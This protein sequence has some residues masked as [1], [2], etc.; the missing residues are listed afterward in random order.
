M[1]TKFC[2]SWKSSIQPRKQR[3]YIYNCPLHI[4]RKFLKCN[5][6]KFLRKDIKKR[7]IVVIKGDKIRVMRGNFKDKE[8]IVKN[9][10]IKKTKIY[11][12]EIKKKEKKG[13]EIFVPL[14][15]SNVQ[16]IELNLKDTKR[17]NK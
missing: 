1:K 9:T 2:A 8:G 16:I 12:E 3:K 13:K 4:K 15:P 6:S 5:L 11:V 10:D 17:I 7:N 14:N